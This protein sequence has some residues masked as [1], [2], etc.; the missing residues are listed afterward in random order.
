MWISSG[1]LRAWRI[2]ATDAGRIK[3][4]TCLGAGADSRGAS[5]REVDDGASEASATPEA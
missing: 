5:D 4:P 2:G 3:P 1:S